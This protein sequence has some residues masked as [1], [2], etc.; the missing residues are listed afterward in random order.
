MG[1]AV[2]QGLEYGDID[3]PHLS[4]CRVFIIPGL[5]KG[6]ELEDVVGAIKWGSMRPHWV[7]SC[8]MA[9]R[10]SSTC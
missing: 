2:D 3:W 9:H 6:L 7:N 10:A 4:G 1:K 8:P 5:E